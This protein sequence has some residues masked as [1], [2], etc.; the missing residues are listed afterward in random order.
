MVTCEDDPAG[1]ARGFTV[2]S[3]VG[4]D[5]SDSG[6]ALGHTAALIRH[7][8][9]QCSDASPYCFGRTGVTG[10]A[11]DT[12]TLAHGLLPDFPGRGAA[13]A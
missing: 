6:D 10:G 5:A 11:T 12:R 1:R 8:N 13:S 2:S 9:D 4:T 3:V 7:G